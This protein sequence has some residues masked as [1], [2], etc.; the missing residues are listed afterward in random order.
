MGHSGVAVLWSGHPE[1]DVDARFDELASLHA[2]IALLEIGA[3]DPLRPCLPCID[4]PSSPDPS[5][6]VGVLTARI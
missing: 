4:L 5:P 1:V 2:Q 6:M 3:R